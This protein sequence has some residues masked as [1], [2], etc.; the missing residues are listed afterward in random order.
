MIPNVKMKIKIGKETWDYAILVRKE[1]EKYQN[2][3]FFRNSYYYET[4]IDEKRRNKSNVKAVFE[5]ILSVLIL[6]I[7]EHQL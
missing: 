1:S 5:L 6:E 7:S 2:K 3:I 4:S